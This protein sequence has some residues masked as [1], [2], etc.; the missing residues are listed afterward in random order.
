VAAEL[1]MHIGR[2][3]G[4]QYQL[5]PLAPQLLVSVNKLS[6]AKVP[7]FLQKYA[8]TNKPSEIS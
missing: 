8:V 2:H 4:S 6:A 3:L 5:G 7:D 1:L